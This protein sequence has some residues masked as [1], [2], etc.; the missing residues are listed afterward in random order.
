M[1]IIGNK[2]I[3]FRYFIGD[4]STKEK[5]NEVVFEK[6]EV[7]RYLEENKKNSYSKVI[8]SVRLKTLD[9]K[10]WLPW[11]YNDDKCGA[12]NKSIETMNHF[13]TCTSC[14]KEPHLNWRQIN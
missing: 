8:F 2:V 10:E 4:K 1:C 11:N 14:R 3:S 13:I 6:L 12:R 7:S 5:T 9:L